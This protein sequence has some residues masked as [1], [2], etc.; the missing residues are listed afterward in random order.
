MNFIVHHIWDV[1]LPIDELIVIFF[2]GVAVETTNQLSIPFQKSWVFTKT[3]K[4]FG[5]TGWN[6]RNY[7][8][9]PAFYCWKIHEKP[10]ET[11]ISFGDFWA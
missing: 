10:I 5:S 4:K 7:L 3:K 11:S 8:E 6:Q 1:I 2:R 9:N